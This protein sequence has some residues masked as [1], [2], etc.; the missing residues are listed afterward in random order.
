MKKKLLISSI[1][2]IVN[3]VSASDQPIVSP[4]C[5]N[6]QDIEYL[7]Y[8]TPADADRE[9]YNNLY[10]RGLFTNPY[11]NTFKPMWDLRY[12]N[13]SSSLF[14]AANHA[15]YTGLDT[16]DGYRASA[17]GTSI[18]RW[19]NA[20]SIVQTKCVNGILTGGVMV[21]LW[22][23]VDQ[24]IEEVKGGPQ[25]SLM[26]HFSGD[27]RPWVNGKS[28]RL[29]AN[30]DR[31]IYTKSPGNMGGNISF[32]ATIQNIYDPKKQF[33]YVMP[34][35]SYGKGY[36][37]NQSWQN[38]GNLPFVVAPFTSTH[39]D[40]TRYAIAYKYSNQ[41][42]EV[43]PNTRPN[44]TSD[45]GKWPHFFRA[46]VPYRSLQKALSDRGYNSRPE[47]WK[48]IMLGIQYEIEENGGKGSIA[49]SFYGFRADI[50]DDP[51][52]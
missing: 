39:N 46:Y 3:N 25:A 37:R 19:N 24:S 22:D 17:F 9:H 42:F 50:T 16:R 6:N 4:Y 10:N 31:P 8:R 11:S 45:D 44:P 51:R 13:P 49:G 48:V 36:T 15:N 1:I 32:V 43:T 18:S 14:D 26:Y 30:F 7:Y 21:N 41:T 34:V 20:G 5:W 52:Q 23:A 29:Q 27:V 33:Y 12:V 2:L 35:W 28:L 38:D 47:D 40:G